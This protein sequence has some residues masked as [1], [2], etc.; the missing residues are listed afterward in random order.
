MEKIKKVIELYRMREITEYLF[1]PLEKKYYCNFFLVLT[2]FGFIFFIGTLAL[3]LYNLSIRASN[4]QFMS[5]LFTTLFYF[6]FYIQSRILY[7]VCTNA[8]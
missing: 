5:G 7:S 8:I 3:L 6:A 1:G 4:V 2:I